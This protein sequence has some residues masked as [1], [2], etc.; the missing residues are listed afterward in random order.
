MTIVQAVVLGILQGL[1]EFLPISSSAHLLLVPWM[2][3]WPESGIQFDVALHMGTLVAVTIY[4]WKDLLDVA[5]QGL[6][7]GTRT[8]SG[9]LGWGVVLGTIPAA[10][11]GVLFEEQIE[12][13]VRE[14]YLL[15]AALL[16][17]MGAVLYYVDKH[18][19]K[20]R[21]LK[22]FRVIDG[23]WMGLG[24]AFALIPGFSRSGTTITTGLLLGYDR[25][26]SAKASFLL[27][28]PII[29]GAGILAFKDI[30]WATVTPA[31]WIGMVVSA[32]AGYAVIAFLMEYLRK[33]TFLVFAW[34][35]AFLAALTVL[36][37][38]VRG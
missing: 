12:K 26:A 33:G 24:Q 6:T 34:Y 14:Q 21:S 32:V 8:P 1:G 9:R 29:A 11:A 20:R 30:N 18:S 35:R 3:G 5:V 22:D 16:A 28:W 7:K 23:F 36:V 10:L 13:V 4:F 25:E 37:Y 38:F 2:L 27:G 17:V 31:F 15:M 19:P